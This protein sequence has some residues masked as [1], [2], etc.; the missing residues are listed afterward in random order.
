[1]PW[2]G[3]GIAGSLHL[4]ILCIEE[5]SRPWLV[6]RFI[7]IGEKSSK[8]DEFSKVIDALASIAVICGISMSTGLLGYTICQQ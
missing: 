6:H 4:P 8:W 1:M 3:Y 7:N 2:S 5:A